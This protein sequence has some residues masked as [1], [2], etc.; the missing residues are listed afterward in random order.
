MRRRGKRLV[1]QAEKLPEDQWQKIKI[2]RSGGKEQ[3]VR[4]NDGMCKLKG[5]EGS[6]RQIILTD[7]G[8]E[9]PTFLITND[10][11]ADAKEIVRKYAR[12]NLVEYIYIWNGVYLKIEQVPNT[13]LLHRSPIYDTKKRRKVMKNN[14]FQYGFRVTI[15]SA[16]AS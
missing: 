5:Y 4:I 7:H 3:S 13:H 15:N 1:S 8:R 12:R 11:N 14:I 2:E 16:L 6:V 10:F 9:K